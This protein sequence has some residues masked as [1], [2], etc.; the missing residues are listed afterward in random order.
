MLFLFSAEDLGLLALAAEDQRALYREGYASA[1][2]ASGPLKELA[3]VQ[4]RERRF[5]VSPNDSELL[6]PSCDAT[7]TKTARLLRSRDAITRTH[8][9]HPC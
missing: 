5:V 2:C 1:A 7:T 3:E 9:A 4:D 6:N 8:F